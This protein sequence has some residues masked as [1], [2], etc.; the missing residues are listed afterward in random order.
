VVQFFKPSGSSKQSRKNKA[1]VPKGKPQTLYI[2]V[3]DQHGKGIALST[4]PIT[5]I[6]GA[7]P[8]ETLSVQLLSESKNVRQGKIVSIETPSPERINAS[9]PV[10]EA[11][12]GCNLQM[13]SAEKG[14]FYKQDAL[15]RYFKRVLKIETDVWQ[16]SVRADI[17]YSNAQSKIGYRRKVRLAVDAR[18]K[19]SVKIGYRQS[20]SNKVIDI[21]TCPILLPQLAESIE[22]LLP[23]LKHLDCIQ[24]VGHIECSLTA[25]GVVLLINFTKSLSKLDLHALEALSEATRV[26]LIGRSKEG[27]LCDFGKTFAT[28]KIADMTG[29]SLDIGEQDFIQVNPSVNRQMIEKALLW[30]SPNEDTKIHDFYC[31]VGNFSVPIAQQ[32]HELVGYEVVQGMVAQAQHNANKNGVQNAQFKTINLSDK[33]AL[34]TLAIKSTDYVLLDPSREGAHELCEVLLK[35]AP[36][37]IVYVSCN[38]NTLVRDLQTLKAQYKVKAFCA[39]DMFPFTQHLEVMALLEQS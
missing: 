4:H 6:E 3:L 36:A 18:Q 19:G 37:R 30:L 26:R 10:Y 21:N 22:R 9:C 34:S 5:V 31:G 16:A 28:L 12:G 14:L 7:L 11:C 23:L 8:K 33:S 29:L 24:K 2:D 38:A 39:L 25:D 27:L 20:G 15:A 17:D 1:S 35:S 13:L 32:C